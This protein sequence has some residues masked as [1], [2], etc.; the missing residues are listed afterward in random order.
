M[1]AIRRFAPSALTILLAILTL[2]IF[3]RAWHG[4]L[5]QPVAIRSPLNLE[6]IFAL[7]AVALAALRVR[8]S[9][10]QPHPAPIDFTGPAIAAALAI[11]AFARTSGFYFVSDDFL[12]L[13]HARAQWSAAWLRWLFSTPGGDG[14]FGPLVYVFNVLSSRLFGPTL[15]AWHWISF[16]IHAVNCV[17][18]YA[19][20]A[21]LGY[22][23]RSGLFCAALFAIHGSRPEAVVWITARF[24]LLSTLF[25][26]LGLLALLK[27]LHATQPAR[28]IL[29]AAALVCM[30][31][32]MLSKESAYAFPM[33]ALLLIATQSKNP[34]RHWPAALA[35]CLT[36]AAVFAY[37]WTLFN[38]IGGYLDPSG[39]PQFLSLTPLVILKSLALRLWS[40]LFFPVNWT[41]PMGA[42][43]ALAIAIYMAALTILCAR[44]RADRRPLI[45]AA[46][47]IVLAALPVVSRLLIPMDTEGSRILYLPSVG[48]CLLA[49]CLADHAN[50]RIA[51]AGAAAILVFHAA[52]LAHNLEPWARESAMVHD[53]CQAVAACARETGKAAIIGAPRKVDGVYTFA[54]G[55]EE[56]VRMQP[57][58]QNAQV[59]LRDAA[60]PDDT[61]VFTWN[62]DRQTLLL[63]W[64]LTTDH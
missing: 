52:A 10:L 50:A 57:G 20:A 5:P 58:A 53:T 23:R 64:P 26:L 33:L 43:L 49:A 54:N 1:N 56:C 48:F 32:G 47:F 11:L 3:A 30:T 4:V 19:L 15:A 14:H 28:A 13:L 16:A 61:C 6:A 55:F 21:A 2:A 24:D 39:R 60:H 17:L 44:A 63:N 8:A 12:I 18:V 27:S 38:G 31:A 41:I 29:L 40:S 37:R 59:V 9:N 7:A 34:I 22:A 42:L 51:I 45:E 25:V 62:A 35:M 36:A 46:A